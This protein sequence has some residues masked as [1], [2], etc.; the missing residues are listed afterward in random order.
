MSSVQLDTNSL[1]Y[2]IL[3]QAK[4]D[5]PSVIFIDEIDAICSQRGTKNEAE[6]SRKVKCEI[7]IQMDGT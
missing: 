3:H 6:C 4:R 5:G 2:F 7:L 1:L